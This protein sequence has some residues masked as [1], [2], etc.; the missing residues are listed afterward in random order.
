MSE[1]SDALHEQ[2]DSIRTLLEV[3]EQ[4]RI[5]D[6]TELREENAKLREECRVV[7][8]KIHHQ[9]SVE[10]EALTAECDAAIALDAENRRLADEGTVAIA[11]QLKAMGA[12]CQEALTKVSMYKSQLEYVDECLMENRDTGRGNTRTVGGTYG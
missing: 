11:R 7:V 8:E 4:R 10:V 6:V 1:Y 2:I 12:D 3:S 5:N 9:W